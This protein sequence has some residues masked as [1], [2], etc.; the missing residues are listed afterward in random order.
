MV[1]QHHT[2]QRQMG[3]LKKQFAKKAKEGT[4]AVLLQLDPCSDKISDLMG[5]HITKG[6][7][8]CFSTYQ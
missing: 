8:E 7:S 1:R 2:D 6:S 3:L 5:K 4:F